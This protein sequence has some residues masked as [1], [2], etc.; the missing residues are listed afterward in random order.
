MTSVLHTVPKRGALHCLKGDRQRTAA[1]CNGDVS[2]SLSTIGSV[3]DVGEIKG[4]DLFKIKSREWPQS[5]A[6]LLVDLHDERDI[7][8]PEGGMGGGLTT[9]YSCFCPTLWGGPH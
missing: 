2:S 3:S 1:S 6:C 9:K 8:S 7:P 5:P 4:K